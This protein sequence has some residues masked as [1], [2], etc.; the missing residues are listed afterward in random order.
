MNTATSMWELAYPLQIRWKESDSSLF[1]MATVTESVRVAENTS[2][3]ADRLPSVSRTVV[4]LAVGCSVLAVILLAIVGILV[5]R[6]RW[7]APGSED[8]PPNQGMSPDQD[9]VPM[10]ELHGHQIP[11]ASNVLLPPVNR[12]SFLDISRSIANID[13]VVSESISDHDFDG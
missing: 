8:G 2:P 10:A 1:S 12:V 13:P 5:Y 9:T 6:R 11:S 3:V 7:Q 4:S